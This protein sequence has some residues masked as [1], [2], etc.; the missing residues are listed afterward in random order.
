M[1]LDL[2]QLMDKAREMNIAEKRCTQALLKEWQDTLPLFQKKI[3]INCHLTIAT[4][5]LIELFLFSGAEIKIT[6][7]EDLVSHESIKEIISNLGIYLS[8]NEVQQE[9]YKEYFDVILDCGAYLANSMRPKIG[10][11]E[12]THVEHSKYV[13][14]NCPIISVDSGFIKNIETTYGTGDGFVRAIE[15]IYL[16]SGANYKNKKYMIFGYGKVGQGIS[17]CLVNSGVPQAN[18][19]IIEANEPRVNTAI[20]DGFLSLSIQNDCDIIKS[21]LHT[22]HC[23]VTATGVRNSI[24]NYLNHKDFLNV[25]YLANMGTY[26][27]WG[28]SFPL[29]SILHQ[30]S[31]LNFMLDYPTK[32]CYLDPIFAVLACATLDIINQNHTPQFII[33]KP[34]L[35]TEKKVLNTWL[36]N[37]TLHQKMREKWLSELGSHA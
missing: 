8:P 11:I 27:E 17:A 4:L 25:E 6:C 33:K 21:F 2:T 5:M 20:L 28:E 34:N 29:D 13:S 22:T 23:A 32:I 24:S 35:A 12:L 1:I 10:F 37:S 36:Q 18:I 14:T 15:E 30:K 3:L 19:T 16:N 7:T 26:D 9:L 31:P